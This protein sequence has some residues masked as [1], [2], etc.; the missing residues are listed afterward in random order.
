MVRVSAVSYTNSIPFVYGLQNTSILNQIELSLDIPSI[1]AEKLISGQADIGL[2]PAAVIPQLEMGEI[3][4]DYCIGAD[5]AVDTVML[6]SQVPITEIKQIWLDFQSR[7]S[8]QLV[9][10]LCRELWKISPQ[11]IQGSYGY[12]NL[13]Q[14]SAAGVIIG[15]R[16]F[17]Q[18]GK[19][20]Y[21]YDLAENW[22]ILTGLPFVF[23]VWYSRIPLSD[24]FKT[25]FS[26]GLRIGLEKRGEAL[27]KL[28]NPDISFE[29][30]SF[31]LNNRISYILDSSKRNSLN[32]FLSKL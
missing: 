5:G 18:V 4:S 30:A 27:L 13:I 17:D 21:S 1:C 12:E 23:A 32:L 31:Y 2:I 9:R 6:Y 22:K 19:F 26:D 28:L 24:L 14:G 16:C 20:Q 7:T 29:S 10:I 11:F 3:I 8:V 15:D 25:E